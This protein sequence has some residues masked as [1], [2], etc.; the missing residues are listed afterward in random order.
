MQS[1][2]QLTRVEKLRM[3]NELWDDL[4]HDAESFQSP[5]WHEQAL[6]NAHQL[7]A[8]GQA[9]MIDWDVAK[10]IIRNSV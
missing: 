2:N 10:E 4:T 3:M 1:L 7:H 8:T 9:E 5:A 6:K